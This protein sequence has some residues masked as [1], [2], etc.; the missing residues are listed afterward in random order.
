MAK[1]DENLSRGT[2]IKK[3]IGERERGK[4]TKYPKMLRKVRKKV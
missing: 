2:Y 1:S 3:V 4:A